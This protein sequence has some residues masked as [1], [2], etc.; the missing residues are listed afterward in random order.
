MLWQHA[1]RTS[2][3]IPK[4]GMIVCSQAPSLQAY[5]VCSYD[6]TRLVGSVMSQMSLQA[7]GRLEALTGAAAASDGPMMIYTDPHHRRTDS[8]VCQD[9][10][11]DIRRLMMIEK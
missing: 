5:A 11:S 7:P 2:S 8:H 10:H 3:C 1:G 4:H 6:G 9:G